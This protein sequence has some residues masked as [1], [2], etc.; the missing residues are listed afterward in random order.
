MHFV[1]LCINTWWRRSS[2]DPGPEPNLWP[3]APGPGLYGVPC[4]WHQKCEKNFKCVQL[5]KRAAAAHSPLW[6]DQIYVAG[7]FFSPRKL[8]TSSPSWHRHRVESLASPAAAIPANVLNPL[9]LGALVS[10]PHILVCRFMT[11]VFVY[12]NI[13]LLWLMCFLLHLA[14]LQAARGSPQFFP[15]LFA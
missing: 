13:I 10:A 14:R 12:P 9:A 5:L 15:F 8:L 4:L 1:K 3:R 6:A 7:C 11:N 2:V